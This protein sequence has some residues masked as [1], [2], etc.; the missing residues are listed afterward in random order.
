MTD[1]Q[2]VSEVAAGKTD[3]FGK[4]YDAY[5]DR[6]YAFLWFRTRHTET[7]EDLTSTVF[8]KAFD[9][10]KQF[11]GGSFRAWL[12]TIART[13]LIDHYRTH[14]PTDD[15]DGLEIGTADD[16]DARIDRQLQLE[17]IHLA[18]RQLSAEQRR[19]VTMRVWDDLP[20]AEIAQILGQTEA[21]VK[22][23]FSR[24][25][26][27]LKDLIIVVALIINVLTHVKPQ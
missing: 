27:K 14:H 5:V 21:A 26:Q 19:V 3:S 16:H 12:Y 15:V 20:H 9:R 17:K 10:L 24:S 18:L 13:T 1:E 7:A 6:I 22:M 2:L 8:L 4:L 23:T 25:V 11:S